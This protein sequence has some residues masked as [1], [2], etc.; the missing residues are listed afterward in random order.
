MKGSLR[1][2]LSLILVSLFAVQA[3]TPLTYASGA[4][5]RANRTQ[6]SD[7]SSSA[8]QV[9]A[10]YIQQVTMSTNDIIYDKNT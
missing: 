10:D 1:V 6:R 4:I 5:R 8:Q 3:I 7:D 9:Q 2:Y